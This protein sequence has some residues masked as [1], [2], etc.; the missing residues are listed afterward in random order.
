M[1]KEF[2][3]HLDIQTLSAAINASNLFVWSTIKHD[4]YCGRGKNVF[5]DAKVINAK[6]SYSN[7]DA[8]AQDA[9]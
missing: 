6:V 9:L 1:N 4:G 8:T 7:D 5:I 3:V 2:Y